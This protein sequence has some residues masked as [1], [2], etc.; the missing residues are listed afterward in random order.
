M[1]IIIISLLAISLLAEG[2]TKQS[3]APQKTANNPCSD[4]QYLELKK[5]EINAMSDREYDYFKTKSLECS[6]YNM[7]N[8]SQEKVSKS[9]NA[10]WIVTGIVTVI[11]IIGILFINAQATKKSTTF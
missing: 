4:P 11:G 5:K 8:E 3:V 1:K 7:I 9:V 2:C 10:V 6:N